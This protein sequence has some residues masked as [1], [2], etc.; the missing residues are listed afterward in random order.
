MQTDRREF[1]AGAVAT[2]ALAGSAA[3]A[4]PA[5]APGGRSYARNVDW[6]GYAD[7]QG[8]Q[9]AQMAL[10]VANGR[11]YLYTGSFHFGGWN[12]LE[13]TD[14]RKPRYL[15]WIEAPHSA[16]T[17]TM[18]VQAA[19]GLLLCF[20][21]QAVPFLR[22]NKWE[23]PFDN[24]VHIFD[25]ATD[26]ANPREIAVWRPQEKG[27]GTHRS[28][29]NGGRYAH[30]SAS[31]DG[32]EGL[33]YRILDLKDPTK[34]VEAGRWWLPHQWVAGGGT[35]HFIPDGDAAHGPPYPKGNFVYMPW[36]GAGLIILD[37][38]DIAVPKLVGRLDVNPPFGG[39]GDP[40]VHTGVPLS[41]RPFVVIGGEGRR[42][43]EVTQERIDEEP[44]GLVLLGL[45]DVSKPDKPKLISTFPMPMPDPKA[46]YRNFQ[47]VPP[48]RGNF[49]FGPHNVHQP[50]GRPELEDRNDRVYCAYFNAGLRIYDI[51]DPYM[52]KEI[53]YFVPPDPEKLMFPDR[54]PG[55]VRHVAED[56]LVDHRG[57]IFMSSLDQ[58]IFVLRATV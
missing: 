52:P 24:G 30:L 16:G 56:V 6:I 19:E 36:S 57:N 4:A 34:P 49:G 18:K 40:P 5:H 55:P 17:W 27:G 12:V 13:V 21:G 7:L 28:F 51:V 26:P 37:I 3:A 23:D 48:L 8:K 35:G 45:A 41:K 31:A 14:P 32:F 47:E 20:S 33:I 50:Q 44:A 58:G 53:G 46:P 38:S 22:G 9:A 54:F 2:S 10:H 43:P 39:G 42:L 1:L 25:I 11:Y 15:K 29:Y